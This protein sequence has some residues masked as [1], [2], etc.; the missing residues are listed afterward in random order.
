MLV[1]HPL[2]HAFAKMRPGQGDSDAITVDG[3]KTEWDLM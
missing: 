2:S 3:V 1:R